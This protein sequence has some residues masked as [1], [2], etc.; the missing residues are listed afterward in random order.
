MIGIKHDRGI[1]R[2]AIARRRLAGRRPAPLMTAL[3]PHHRA[4]SG[5][6]QYEDDALDRVQ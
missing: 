2:I 5:V 3:L 4:D 1:E 6:H